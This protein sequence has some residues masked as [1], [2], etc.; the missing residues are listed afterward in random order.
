MIDQD[1]DHA[2]RLLRAGLT[3]VTGTD[4]AVEGVRAFQ[5]K[6]APVWTGQ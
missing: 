5:E 2:L 6:R 4:D 1:A 3:L